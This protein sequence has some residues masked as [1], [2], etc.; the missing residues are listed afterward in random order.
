MQGPFT[1]LP[2]FSFK[3]NVADALVGKENYPVEI[4]AGS[5]N[6]QAFNA[7]IY[8]GDLYERLEGSQSFR[9]NLRGPIRKAVASAAIDLTGGPA[10]VKMVATG[11]ATAVSGEKCVGIAIYPYSKAAAAGDIVSYIKTDCIMP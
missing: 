11:L 3:E 8:I 4:V 10:Y 9:V 1:E 2:V 6:I 5:L 7:G